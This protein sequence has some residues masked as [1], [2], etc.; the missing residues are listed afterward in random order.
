MAKSGK[1]NPNRT[2]AVNRRARFEYEIL[3]SVV[4]GMVLVGTEVKSL[5]DGKITLDEAFVRIQEDEMFLV[6]AH[7]PE[8]VHGNVNNHEPRRRRKLLMH[9]REIRRMK[10]E[11][12]QQGL[13]L[14]PLHLFWSEKGI[15]KLE[16]GLARG[17]K[18]RDKRQSIRARDDERAM[19]DRR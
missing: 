12:G 9:R 17:K 13:T 10:G 19:R 16:V 3:E 5:R 15:A 2:I 8:Y 6:K 14:V 11:L 1:Q 4:A 7:I 18:T